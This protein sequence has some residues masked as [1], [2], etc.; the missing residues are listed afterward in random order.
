[1]LVVLLINQKDYE[2]FNPVSRK[3]GR[4]GRSVGGNAAW[5]DAAENALR[6]A[7]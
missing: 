5:R 6:I 4:L 1:M 7:G 2:H 3:V